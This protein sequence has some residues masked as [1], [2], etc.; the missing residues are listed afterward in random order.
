MFKGL[1]NKLFKKQSDRLV[2]TFTGRVP[3]YAGMA[4]G[5]FK[6]NIEFRE[7][8][9]ECNQYIIKAGGK[10][11]LWLF[12]EDNKITIFDE[13][14]YYVYIV[15]IEV[16]ILHLYKSRGYHPDAVLGISNGE[17]VAAYAAGAIDIEAVFIITVSCML[18]H[19]E[20]E[21]YTF[22]YVQLGFDAALEFCQNSAV[23]TEVVYEMSDDKVLLTVRSKDIEQL[24]ELLVTAQIQYR[25][26][27]TH[28][29][30]YHTS[31][32][33][34]NLSYYRERWE[35]MVFKPLQCEY[36]SSLYG[37]VIPK[38]FILDYDYFTKLT[39]SPCVYNSQ[40]KSAIKDGYTAFLQLGP[41]FITK[42]YIKKVEQNKTYLIYSLKRG[43]PEIENLQNTYKILSR[44]GIKRKP[45]EEDMR[46]KTL[47]YFLGGFN[48]YKPDSR[49]ELRYLR[50]EGPIHFL[51]SN[52]AWILLNYDD[53]ELV[54]KNEAYF[55]SE[56][57][58]PIDAV[59]LSSSG[60][61]HAKSKELLMRLFS[62][63]ALASLK[64]VCRDTA[65]SLLDSL[66]KLN[67]FDI[68]KDFS[69]PLINKILFVFFGFTDDDYLFLETNILIEKEVNWD[70]YFM[71]L[72]PFFS[73][74]INNINYRE[75]KGIIQSMIG[76]YET[77]QMNREEVISILRLFWVASSETTTPFLSIIFNTILKQL[78]LS[79]QI[80][81]DDQLM[82]KFI[83]ECLRLESSS[84]ILR[85]TTETVTVAGIQLPK[86]SKLAINLQSANTDPARFENPLEFSLSRPSKRNLSFGTGMHQCIGMGMARAFAQSTLYVILER[87][88]E[89]ELYIPERPIY[90][91]ANVFDTM[92]SLKVSK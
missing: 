83:E 79:K 27:G 25:A 59:L 69:N 5:L 22:I 89:V 50:S 19:K 15:A 42:E 71:K 86:G 1:F 85:I 40:I 70:S 31:L 32:A 18:S 38:N 68:V 66:L 29:K 92:L 81:G 80:Q 6:N 16:A 72:E 73:N 34:Y 91:Y 8:I 54:L 7:K 9:F 44:L 45:V 30:V 74:C 55:S 43:L 57:Y 28:Y 64:E 11:I 76:F 33:K 88:S 65:I 46:L 36:Y 47:N 21:Q 52:D 41:E 3:G 63:T 4:S 61:L 78:P 58:A 2:F 84:R 75:R 23:W 49:M 90:S 37:K 24:K 13:E 62:N 12:E 14:V 51:P 48:I 77:G 39:Y 35:G 53:I 87:L 82:L 17:P 26:V 60:E 67:E 56:L 10:D 20:L